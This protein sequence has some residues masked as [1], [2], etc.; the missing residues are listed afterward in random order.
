MQL[1]AYRSK[2]NK[3]TSQSQS[4]CYTI[5]IDVGGTN[6]DC[7]V[8][9]GTELIGWA[10]QP[11]SENVTSGVTSALSAALQDAC[12]HSGVNKAEIIGQV[13]QVNIGTTH[14]VNAVVQRRCLAPVAAIRLCGP[15]KI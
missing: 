8:L 3:M 12:T 1:V 9:R 2:S 10:K 4:Q 7:V 14:F 6:T 13:V 5:G 11:T 15:G